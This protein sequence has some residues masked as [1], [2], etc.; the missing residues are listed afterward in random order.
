MK[1]IVLFLVLAL[2]LLS[3]HAQIKKGQW[4]IG[5][6][7]YARFI[8]EDDF[9]SKEFTIS[10]D[11]GYF[12]RDKLAG[13]LR[14]NLTHAVAKEWGIKFATDTYYSLSPFV[15]YYLLSKTAQLN[16]FVDGGVYLGKVRQKG[17]TDEVFRATTYGYTATGG[18]A[19]FIKN[20]VALEA[21]LSLDKRDGKNSDF[22]STLVTGKVGLQFHL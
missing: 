8:K 16:P 14:V 3:T 5:G 6:N 7:G 13:G 20:L 11:A 22:S 15:R 9:R 2:S 18:I 4:L 12:F 19:Y 10:P 21:Q 1:K 17:T